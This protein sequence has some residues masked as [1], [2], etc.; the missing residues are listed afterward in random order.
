VAAGIRTMAAMAA[1]AR[2]AAKLGGVAS[3]WWRATAPA[4]A[5][6][7]TLV[8][9]A[10]AIA[11]AGGALEAYGSHR[12]G[13]HGHP[14]RAGAGPGIEIATWSLDLVDPS[15]IGV[16]GRYY[17][18]TS[19]PFY[20]PPD[21]NVP[22]F[23]GAP[24]HFR[25][26][27]DALPVVPPWALPASEGGQVWDPA[28][29]RV[30]GRYLLYFAAQLRGVVHATHCIG[31]ASSRSPG[32]P[33]RPVAGPPLLCQPLLGGDIDPQVFRSTG[34]P[35]GPLRHATLL[36][37]SDNNNLPGSGPTTI[38]A[39]PL[40]SDGLRLTGTPR[41]LFVPDR[42]WEQPVLEA[43]QMARAPNGTD[44]LF[45]SAGTGYFSPRYAIGVARCESPLGGCY[46]VLPGPLLAS[47][48]Q[49]SGPGEEVVFVGSDGST[50]LLY[51]P[52]HAGIH[53]APMRPIEAA[54]IEWVRGKPTVDRADRF[55]PAGDGG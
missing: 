55:P 30:G 7:V 52:W 15:L 29:V 26:S 4:V 40:S 22:S 18:F 32:G 37:K 12:G 51:S 14:S 31:V 5:T 35:D 8:A 25:P 23:V 49:G 6:G 43:P 19:T 9:L 41:V 54:R 10:L 48:A 1:G 28:V 24:G 3:R 2:F 27:G 16:R 39:A 13:G 17:L 47:N 20:D 36:W 21:L 38:W 34:R 45:F 44:W 46:E 42:V 50:W 11:P 53:R 33:F